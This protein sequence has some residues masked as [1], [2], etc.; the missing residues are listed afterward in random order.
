MFWQ[1]VFFWVAGTAEMRPIAKRLGQ[2]LRDPMKRVKQHSSVLPLPA[3]PYSCTLPETGDSFQRTMRGHFPKVASP[4]L[5]CKHM[6][7]SQSTFLPTTI[8]DIHCRKINDHTR[9]SMDTFRSIQPRSRNTSQRRSPCFAQL[10]THSKPHHPETSMHRLIEL[11]RECCRP[12]QRGIAGHRCVR[13]WPCSPK[14][15]R[16]IPRHNS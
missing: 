3:S 2:L 12:I 10:G 9:R 13:G 15:A 8:H 6:N 7:L 11:W 4:P 14:R 1:L 5:F 16:F